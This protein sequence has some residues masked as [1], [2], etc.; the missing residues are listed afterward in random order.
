MFFQGYHGDTSETFVVGE[1]D[2]QGQRLV[3]AARLCR[4]EGINVCKHGALFDDIGD[5]I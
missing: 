1:T 3:D 5:V 4:D 2:E